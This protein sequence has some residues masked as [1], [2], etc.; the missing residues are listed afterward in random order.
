MQTA[1]LKG[2]IEILLNRT[3]AEL[4]DKKV[5]AKAPQ[6]PEYY[7]AQATLSNFLIENAQDI[8]DALTKAAEVERIATTLVGY[9]DKRIIPWTE[10]HDLRT[11]LGIE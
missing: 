7:K 8:I 1:Q 10:W 9:P 2:E 11:A 5:E 4:D 6:S 3:Y